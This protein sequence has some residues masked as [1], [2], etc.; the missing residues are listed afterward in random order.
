MKKI[1]Y[2]IPLALLLCSSV[3]AQEALSVKYNPERHTLTF[4]LQNAPVSAV[5]DALAQEG[6]LLFIVEKDRSFVLNGVQ[7]DVPADDALAEIMPKAYHY[8]YRVNEQGDKALFEQSAIG[9][10]KM[11]D[12]KG[13]K[14]AAKRAATGVLLPAAQLQKLP[15]NA[16]RLK[17]QAG[18]ADAVIGRLQPKLPGTGVMGAPESLKPGAAAQP[19]STE[20]AAGAASL[21]KVT[22]E[23][24]VVTFKV[25]KTGIEPVR[26][27]LETG[28]YVPE[29][30][31]TAKGDYA[32]IGVENSKVVLIESIANPLEA[33]SVFDPERKVEHGSF[34]QA[35]S[36][37]TVKMPK[38]YTQTANYQ[39]LKLQLTRFEVADRTAIYQKLKGN[40]LIS[41]DFNKSVNILRSA[42][43][44]NLSKLQILKR[45]Q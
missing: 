42:P 30:E 18:D 43:S 27:V 20:E 33:H 24:L 6:F 12:Q 3:A 16:Y 2:F 40:Q 38:K 25:T 23:H 21:R 11:S 28:A 13:D 7:N 39:K 8:F 36:Y 31:S 26:A 29:N 37:I 10:K 32:L 1:I 9:Q 35:E 4:R 22:D 19:E 34:E 17:P 44:L 15:A 45:G 5:I 41:T 14:R